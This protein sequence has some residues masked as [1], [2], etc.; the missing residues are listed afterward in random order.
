MSNQKHKGDHG[1]RAEQRAA[2]KNP[3][4]LK[5]PASAAKPRRVFLRNWLY[6][7]ATLGV[8]AAVTAL[9]VCFELLGLWDNVIGSI[10]PFEEILPISQNMVRELGIYR[11]QIP[12]EKEAK[13]REDFDRVR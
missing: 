10:P 2:K 3:P 11:D 4:V 5:N 7:W 13:P 12:P 9:I 1:R 6:I 8:V